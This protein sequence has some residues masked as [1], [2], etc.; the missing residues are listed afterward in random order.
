MILYFTT[1]E[2]TNLLDFLKNQEEY[3]EVSIT[4]MTGT[5]ELS[6]FVVRDMRNFSHFT[7][8]VIDRTA[9]TDADKEF[10]DAIEQFLTMYY[11]RITV[12]DERLTANDKLFGQLLDIGVGN[13]VTAFDIAT[14]QVEI[15]ACISGNG[16]Q[17]Y[18]AKE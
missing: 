9:F 17:K 14:I 3:N 13:I 7:E 5:F 4:K 10:V 2:H 1:A 6:Q 8:V 11:A 12:I 16:L 15:L 18:N